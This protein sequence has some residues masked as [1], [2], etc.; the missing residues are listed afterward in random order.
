[1]VALSFKCNVGGFYTISA[2]E[3]GEFAMVELEDLVTGTFTDLLKESYTFK[4][5]LLNSENR[6]VVHFKPLFVGENFADMINIY[7]DNHV[8]YVSVPAQT[9]GSVKVYNLLGQEAASTVIT[10][11]ITRITLDNSA[12]YIIEVI[13]D[14]S[15]VTKK[16]FVK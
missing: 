7:S 2:T 6:F 4:H 5:E 14:G 9:T 8:V 13:S 10:D 11:L 16:V 15:V 3:T 12:Y 1:M